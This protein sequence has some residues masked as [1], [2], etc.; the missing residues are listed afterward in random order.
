MPV[1]KIVWPTRLQVLLGCAHYHYLHAIGTPACPAC[2]PSADVHA[3][4]AS[5]YKAADRTC[6]KPS[7]V[8]RARLAVQAVRQLHATARSGAT[9]CPHPDCGCE[10][11]AATAWAA[12]RAAVAGAAWAVYRGAAVAVA[13]DSNP[14]RRATRRAAVASTRA[15]ARRL[16]QGAIFSR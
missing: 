3:A 11:V 16:V 5:A 15:R 6:Y 13:I 12:Y 4:L 7:D 1:R 8:T 9:A 14:A 2:P 10:A